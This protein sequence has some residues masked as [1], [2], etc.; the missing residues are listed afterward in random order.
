MGVVLKELICAT[1]LGLMLMLI[2]VFDMAQ[3][4]PGLEH[5]L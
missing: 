2:L 4:V 5:L 1:L 3:S